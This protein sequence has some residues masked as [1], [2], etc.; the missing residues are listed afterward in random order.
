MNNRFKEYI[1]NKLGVPGSIVITTLYSDMSR[2]LK[3]DEV[4]IAYVCGAPYVLDHDFFGEE[5][6]AVP[7]PAFSNGKPT[8][9]SYVIVRKD[10]PYKSLK[11]L[12]MKR[13]ALS[14]PL[15]NS[16][17]LVPTYLLARKGY[18]LDE[19]FHSYLYTYS[20]SNSIEAVAM[21][22]VDGASVDGYI[23]E[24]HQRIDP[25]FSSQTKVIHK[26]RDFPFTPF[27]IRNSID[28]KIKKKIKNI[29]LEMH[30][31]PEGKKV[32]DKLFI[33]RFVSLNDKDYDPIREMFKFVDRFNGL[34]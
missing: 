28:S 13:Y 15:S 24:L 5:L 22:L 25:T 29:F 10:S 21:G 23:W 12:Q 11:D 30:Q 6:L 34:K 8:Y 33:E 19:Y 26:S 14:D 31:N 9:K 18:K 4:D 3:N 32:L 27:V 17:K 7:I 1:S 20:H 16:G 2:M